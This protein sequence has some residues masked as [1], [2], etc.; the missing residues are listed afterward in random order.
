M[1][2]DLNSVQF[3]EGRNAD[4]TAATQ[5]AATRNGT[6]PVQPVLQIA[7]LSKTFG[8]THAS[9]WKVRCCDGWS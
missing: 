3:G 8:A 1:A 9:A 6:A 4:M 5:E 2:F 7:G